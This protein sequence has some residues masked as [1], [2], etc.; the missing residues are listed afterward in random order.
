MGIQRNW[1][2]QREIRNEF[3]IS[4]NFNHFPFSLF[5]V[6]RSVGKFILASSLSRQ[7]S[8]VMRN[9]HVVLFFSSYHQPSI[10]ESNNPNT[11][12]IDNEK[13]VCAKIGLI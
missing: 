8:K 12:I 3:E 11:Y 4:R 7:G 1:Y 5:D 9:F 6:V 10:F 2:Y 13:I